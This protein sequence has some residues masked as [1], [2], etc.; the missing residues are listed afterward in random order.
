VVVA[1]GATLVGAGGID[2]ALTV[3]G[4]VA[5]GSADPHV[6]TLAGVLGPAETQPETLSAS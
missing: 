2:G 4:D 5:A 3:S 1:P 6:A